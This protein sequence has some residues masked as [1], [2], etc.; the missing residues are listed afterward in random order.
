[1]YIHTYTTCTTAMLA[2][3]VLAC[4]NS[5]YVLP[6]IYTRTGPSKKIKKSRQ[7]TSRTQTLVSRPAALRMGKAVGHE[8]TQ[9]HHAQV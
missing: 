7:S 2:T 9:T 4:F 6:R 5:T 8:T 1:M 3:H